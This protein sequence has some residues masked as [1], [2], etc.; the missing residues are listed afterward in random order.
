MKWQFTTPLALH[1]NGCS[2]SLVKTTKSCLKKAI[3][4]A[5]LTPFELYTCLLEV[6]N[7]VNERPSEDY[8]TIQT[9]ALICVQTTFCWADQQAK[10]PKVHSTRRK[11]LA[12]GSSSAKRSWNHSG[13]GGPMMFSRYWCQERNGM[14]RLGM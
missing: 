11:I 2:E 13:K 12:I 7:L 14:R 6:A 10:F 1:Q 9:M 5:V 8:Q 4:E 3:G